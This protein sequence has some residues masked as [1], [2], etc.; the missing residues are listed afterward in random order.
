MLRGSYWSGLQFD[1]PNEPQLRTLHNPQTSLAE[2]IKMGGG[3]KVPYPK[4]VWSPAGGWYAQPANWRG[5]TIIAGAVIFGIAAVTWKFSAE[6]ETFARKPEPG[7]WYPSRKYVHLFFL[8]F[9]AETPRFASVAFVRYL[10]FHSSLFVVLFFLRSNICQILFWGFLPGGLR[11]SRSESRSGASTTSKHQSNPHT[12]QDHIFER[13]FCGTLQALRSTNITEP[14]FP[15]NKLELIALRR[16]YIFTLA[17]RALR[18]AGLAVGLG[19]SAFT[20]YQRNRAQM[21]SPTGR[22]G[23]LDA[24]AGREVV[25]CHACSNEWYRDEHGLSCPACASDITEIVSPESDPREIE[26]VHHASAS[27]SPEVPPHP[28]G[29][30]SDPEEA[31]IEEHLGPRGFMYRRSVRHDPENDH[32]NPGIEPVLERFVDM[33]HA[34]GPPRRFGPEGQGPSPTDQ[35][36]RFGEPHIHRAT[37]TSNTLGGGTASVTIFSGPAPRNF[38]DG[39]HGGDPFQAIFSNVI[40]DMGPPNAQNEGGPTPNFARSLQDILSLF[41]PA[42]GVA[43]DAVYSQEAL[44]RII[45]SLM[46]ANPQSNAAPPATEQGLQNLERRTVDE[47]LHGRE[48]RFECAVCIDEMKVGEL[49]AFLPCKHVFHDECVVAWLKEHNT[50]PVCRAPIEKSGSTGDGSNRNSETPGGR[51]GENAGSS[52]PPPVPGNRPFPLF[53]S[54]QS[55]ASPNS[56]AWSQGASPSPG[57]PSPGGAG[58]RPVRLSRPPSHS[59]SLLNEAMRGISSRQ[60]DQERERD[61]ERERGATSG[62]SYDTSRL[63]R[64]TSMSPTSP[65]VAA[66]E[67]G[68]RMRERSPSESSTSRRSAREAEAQRQSSH[69]GGPLSWLRDRFSGSGGPGNGSTRDDRRG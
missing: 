25:Y 9:V 51:S 69:G 63:Q 45:S 34:F 15:F 52:G 18:L 35:P 67:Q 58:E 39:P 1:H 57:I 33:I 27:T 22:Q 55:S 30:D 14:L 38:G 5:N 10:S 40:R 65:R 17:F 56:T 43:G 50:C 64:R 60:F 47:E 12:C 20:A 66:G 49:V 13:L 59:Q 26:D 28:Y 41:S 31:D 62:F 68:S 8:F 11:L 7:G 21:D 42:G 54:M 29:E 4:H 6:R 3:G 44:D 2:S 16:P 53:G 24:T 37:F 23:H 32:H 46:E 19:I 48:D 61:R 36:R